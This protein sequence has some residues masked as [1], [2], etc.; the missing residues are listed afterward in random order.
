MGF[1]ITSLAGI[2][3]NQGHPENFGPACFIDTRH[4]KDEIRAVGQER[5]HVSAIAGDD[6]VMHRNTVWQCFS[7]NHAQALCCGIVKA[8]G[9]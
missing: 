1:R 4:V 6:G 9:Y 2:V 8:R 7:N 5:K 3:F